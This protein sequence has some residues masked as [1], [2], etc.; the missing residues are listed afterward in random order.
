MEET[1]SKKKLSKA[2][3]SRVLDTTASVQV[4]LLTFSSC[5]I[6]WLKRLLFIRVGQDFQNKE[7]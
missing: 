1:A 3:I 7:I 6:L 4:D 2:A 5:C